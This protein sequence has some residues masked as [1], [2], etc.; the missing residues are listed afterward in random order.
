MVCVAMVCVCVYVCVYVRA[1]ACVTLHC[2]THFCGICGCAAPERPSFKGQQ[3]A[4]GGA[5]RRWPQ[6]CKQ[7]PVLLH[8]VKSPSRRRWNVVMPSVRA[9]A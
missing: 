3:L 6:G 7:A 8:G 4:R 9:P 2:P 5:L 1:R